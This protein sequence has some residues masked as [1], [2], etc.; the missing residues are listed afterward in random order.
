M[1]KPRG[2]APSVRAH[3]H[4]LLEGFLGLLGRQVAQR[5]HA[6]QHIVLA[7]LGAREI[8]DRIEAR[9]RLGN[10]G[11]HG[12]LGRRHFRQRLAQVGARGGREAVGA[13]AQVDLVHVERQDLVLA[14]LGLDLEGQQQLV[15]LARVGLF[16]RQVEVARHLHGDGAA[17]LA[18]G[19]LDHVGQDRARHAHPV[20]AAVAVETVVLGRQHGI[21][22]DFG[23]FIE[24]QHVAVFFTI[25]ADQDLVGR[26]DAQRHARPVIG[27]GVQVGQA[28]PGQ[29][30]RQAEQ[31]GG[32]DAGAGHGDAGLD[33]EGLPGEAPFAARASE[34][35]W[36]LLIAG[37][38][39]A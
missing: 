19:A 11:Q 30:Q 5:L 29:R 31:H 18:L 38:S 21:A 3:D 27:H 22:H 4:A 17:A 13:V 14:K 26:V 1:A 2:L 33:Q 36:G 16:R 6:V 12:G 8:G 25:F 23:N 35:C 37:D 10:A 32:A 39:R 20:H 15:E 9:R 28:G 7:D 34:E 24:A